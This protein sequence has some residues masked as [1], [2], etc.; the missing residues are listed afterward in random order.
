VDAGAA[1]SLESGDL[2]A[3]EVAADAPV[4]LVAGG[5]AVALGELVTVDG[6]LAIRITERLDKPEVSQ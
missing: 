6:H 5:R 4:R 1:L 2:L 3:L